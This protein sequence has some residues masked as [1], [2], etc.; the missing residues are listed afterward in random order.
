M[1]A[2]IDATTLNFNVPTKGLKHV[3]ACWHPEHISGRAIERATYMA[4]PRKRAATDPAKM[5]VVGVLP[6]APP[7]QK[8]WPGHLTPSFD[9][10]STR[11]TWPEG[12]SH[13]LHEAL[14]R[15]AY[16]PKS[17]FEQVGND[18]AA[19]VAEYVPARHAPEHV[20]APTISENLP[21]AHSEHALDPASA[22][23]LPA[24]HSKH[25]TLANNVAPVQSLL[26][27]GLNVDNIV[28]ANNH[29]NCSNY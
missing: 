29:N 8:R 22:S 16:V 11:H 26:L 27:V 13:R 9:K 3:I 4:P 19:G 21:P 6:E 24:G 25:V 18:I 28:R 1:I 23:Y 15:V 20:V 14:P 2:S 17:H 12:A 5:T 10:E 7:G